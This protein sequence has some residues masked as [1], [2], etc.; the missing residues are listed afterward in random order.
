[1]TFRNVRDVYLRIIAISMGIP[2]IMMYPSEF[3]VSGENGILLWDPD[4]LNDAIR[5]Y[6]GTLKNWNKAMVAAY[7]LGK[8]FDTKH[9]VE[10]WKGVMDSFE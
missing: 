5:Y 1:M 3:M 9:Q 6:L 2:Q 8:K 7:E 10:N 4:R